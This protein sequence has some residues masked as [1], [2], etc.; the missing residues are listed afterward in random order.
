MA[1]KKK[2]SSSRV[3]KKRTKKKVTKKR[4]TVRKKSSPKKAPKKAT[5]AKSAGA[6]AKSVDG[7][8]K[9][10]AK[11]RSAQVSQL[12]TLSKKIEELQAKTRVYDVHI[13]KLKS[14]ENTTQAAIEKLDTRR[15]EEVGK[16]LAKLGVQLGDGGF[17]SVSTQPTPDEEDQPEADADVNGDDSGEEEDE[18]A[19]EVEE[20]KA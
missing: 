4:K 19:D 1:K 12:A 16:L 5:K 10:H 3:S 18:D 17:G 6:G 14:Q 7:M 2:N 11:D 8:L 20:D 9:K 13:A 15:D